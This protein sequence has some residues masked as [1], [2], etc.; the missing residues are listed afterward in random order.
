M[1]VEDGADGADDD[2]APFTPPDPCIHFL[3]HVTYNQQTGEYFA[4]A[5]FSFPEGRVLAPTKQMANMLA[6]AAGAVSETELR[7][8]DEMEDDEQRVEVIKH[9]SALRESGVMKREMRV[10]VGMGKRRDH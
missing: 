8:L 6:A 3:I 2:A 1:A 9:I 4:L 5:D 7:M 10:V